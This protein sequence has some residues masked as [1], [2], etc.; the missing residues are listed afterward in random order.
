MD[1]FFSYTQLTGRSGWSFYDADDRG[2]QTGQFPA[3][4]LS[5]LFEFRVIH[6]PDLSPVSAVGHEIICNED[7]AN[8]KGWE[9][10]FIRNVIYRRFWQREE[11]EVEGEASSTI[12]VSELSGEV[13]EVLVTVWAENTDDAANLEISLT[14]PSGTTVVLAKG[15]NGDGTIECYQY[16]RFADHAE[17]S[18]TDSSLTHFE[19]LLKPENALS[20][21]V[22]ESKNGVWTLTVKETDGDSGINYFGLSIH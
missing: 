15:Q 1:E 19:D 13:Q 21:F 17:K 20:K 12:T 9:Y 18:V 8:A 11:V 22:G 10:D 6:A 14:S 2:A 7:I 5:S 3:S 16:T 4:P